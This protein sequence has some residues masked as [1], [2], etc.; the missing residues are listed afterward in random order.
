MKAFVL[1]AMI[2]AMALP[3]IA[4]PFA[5]MEKFSPHFFTNTPIL[6][7]ATNQ[8]PKDFW[9]YR[10][11]LPHIFSASVISNAIVLASL[12]K[13]GFPEPSANN[14]YMHED[15][16]PNYP[17]PIPCY[18]AIT[19]GDAHLY[20]GA[21]H[22]DTNSMDIP[23]DEI[24][25]QQAQNS[26]LH[27]GIDLNQVVVEKPSSILS[28]DKDWHTLTNQICGRRVFLSRQLDGITFYDHDDNGWDEG[29][30]FALGSGGK[31]RSF[32]LD[33]PEVKRAD[34]C[35]T[36][37]VQEIIA[38]IRAHRIIVLPNVDE[39]MY[40][41][42]VKALANAKAF[43]ITNITQ[44]YLDGELGKTNQNYVP[45]KYATPIAELDAVADFG[46]SNATVRIFS[47]ILSSD[48]TR[49][50]TK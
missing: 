29:L 28:R 47:F 43:S 35:Q 9:I 8:L 14:F 24:L 12:E 1:I 41:Q 36:A 19:P 23:N 30:S 46:N 20:Y 25:I 42:R 27:L 32:Y 44:Y 11:I 6:W 5:S 37:S 33:W 38:L 49:A 16:G 39:E 13:N 50:L 10:R 3:S 48:V 17:G 4:D 31:I 22:P 45:P 18:F 2:S 26:A 15:K 21:P 34:L 40:F 7:K